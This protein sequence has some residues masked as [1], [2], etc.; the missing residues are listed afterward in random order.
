MLEFY[1]IKWPFSLLKRP[2]KRPVTINEYI[3]K[4]KLMNQPRNGMLLKTL[5]RSPLINDSPPNTNTRKKYW[6][7]QRV[8]KG[9]VVA[10][11]ADLIVPHIATQRIAIGK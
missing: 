9:T 1:P 2:N 3:P 8:I 7:R 6:G 4:K 11:N 5:F 10:Q